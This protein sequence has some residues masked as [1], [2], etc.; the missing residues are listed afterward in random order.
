MPSE[1]LHQ[2]IA[3]SMWFAAAGKNGWP[4]SSLAPEA[5]QT[6]DERAALIDALQ[7]WKTLHYQ[8]LIG[9]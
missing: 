8:E 6:E 1:K 9:E 7:D 5:P 4:T 3:P 2:L